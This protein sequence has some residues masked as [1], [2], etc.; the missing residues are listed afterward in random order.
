MKRTSTIKN[1]MWRIAAILII[2]VFSL[3]EVQAQCSCTPANTRTLPAQSA[4]N[5]TATASGQTL[6]LIGS[7]VYT[8]TIDFANFNDIKLCIG[9]NVIFIAYNGVGSSRII[10]ANSGT[11]SLPNQI[12]N[13]G[14][15]ELLNLNNPSGTSIPAQINL[16][17]FKLNNLTN[18]GQNG[19]LRIGNNPF[20]QATMNVNSGGSLTNATNASITTFNRIDVN[21]GG[22]LT[23]QGLLIILDGTLGPLLTPGTLNVA[24]NGTVN[25]TG[26]V[27]TANQVN[28]GG[29]SL[30]AQGIELQIT[31]DLNQSGGT[32]TAQNAI[33]SVGDDFNLSGNGLLSIQS[34]KITVGDD[35]SQFGTSR[36]IGSNSNATCG[37]INVQGTSSISGS[38]IF[39]SLGPNPATR[40]FL[41]MCD[42]GTTSVPVE[43]SPSVPSGFNSRTSPALV[44]PD[45]NAY[46]S[47]CDCERIIPLPVTLIYFRATYAEGQVKL[48]WATASE[49]NNNF[50]TIEKSKD[51]VNF[52][53][54]TRVK[55]AGTTSSLRTYQSADTQPY[56]GTSYYR[57]KQTDLDGKF[58]YSNIRSVNAGAASRTASVFPNPV[59][60]DGFVQVAINS[61]QTGDI[62][63]TV[64]DQIGK[65]CFSAKYT[66]EVIP[67]IPVKQFS[68]HSGLYIVQA[69]KG[70]TIVREKVIVQ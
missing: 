65:Q 31:G 12:N 48:N 37:S 40:T 54:V 49:E 69:R 18:A 2:G 3:S 22:T 5:L 52:T 10:R 26:G 68:T 64:Y 39:G 20:T 59:A 13:Y 30:L 19:I 21:N 43:G 15:L 57:L 35:Y 44:R 24:T 36:V 9:S 25:L 1:L 29:G 27:F 67:S 11:A 6:C 34:A 23:N 42:N 46:L 33:I 47:G 50:F 16:N 56:E 62:Y 55:G 8:G 58:T 38:A 63:V 41:R 53:E 66:S 14:Q 17:N 45:V 70:N 7:G 28:I 61:E 4:L 60:Q 51:G 32:V